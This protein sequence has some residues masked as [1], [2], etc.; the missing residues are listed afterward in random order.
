[1]DSII[2]EQ[3]IKIRCK[4]LFIICCISSFCWYKY[5][6]LT[7]FPKVFYIFYINYIIFMFYVSWDTYMMCFSKHHIILFRKDLLIHHIVSLFLACLLGYSDI[8]FTNHLIIMEC[9]SLM[10][11]TLKNNFYMLNLYF[12]Q[13]Y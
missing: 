3:H 11:Y 7:L 9:I 1:M 12:Y 4:F 5:K 2:R 6:F 10:N 8:I 13:S